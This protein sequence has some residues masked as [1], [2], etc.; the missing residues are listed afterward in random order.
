MV[1]L[2]RLDVTVV[3]RGIGSSPLEIVAGNPFDNPVR[4]SAPIT[5]T[6]ANIVENREGVSVDGFD[7]SAADRVRIW[8]DVLLL[9]SSFVDLFI[10]PIAANVK[11]D[12]TLDVATPNFNFSGRV[13]VVSGSGVANIRPF[14]LRIDS[15]NLRGS[16]I[17]QADFLAFALF[18]ASSTPTPTAKVAAALQGFLGK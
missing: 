5:S 8:W 10:N 1:N 2:V 14:P 3:E 12:G 11:S 9:G 6:S 18:A 4:R 17:V 13:G 7:V 16:I 15:N